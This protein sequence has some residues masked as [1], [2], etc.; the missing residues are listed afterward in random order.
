MSYNALTL[1]KSSAIG[2]AKTLRFKESTSRGIVSGTG[3]LHA[4]L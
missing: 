4:N 2:L 3:F 1:N